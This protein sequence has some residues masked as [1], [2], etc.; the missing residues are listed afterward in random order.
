MALITER[1]RRIALVSTIIGSIALGGSK[2]KAQDGNTKEQRAEA[3]FSTARQML[4][5]RQYGAACPKLEQSQQLDPAVGTLLYLAFCY[6][7]TGR[8]S[9][10]W[11]TYRAAEIAAEAVGQKERVKIAR[12]RAT[13]LEP[14]L[15]QVSVAPECNSSDIEFEIDEVR[16]AAKE[17]T[18]GVR[19][20][21]G[22]HLLRVQGKSARVREVE[23][24][25]RLGA[26]TVIPLDCA[27]VSNVANGGSGPSVAT[28]PG[29]AETPE[30]S[31]TRAEAGSDRGVVVRRWMGIATGTVGVAALG[32]ATFYA[33]DSA[34]K[35][36]EAEKYRRPRSDVYDEPGFTLNREALESRTIAI[37]G[38]AVSGLALGGATVLLW[39]RDPATGRNAEQHQRQGIR[40]ALSPQS[41]VLAGR[42][43]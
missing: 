11:R 33:L 8:I 31:D 20:E 29:T 3:L 5:L 25:T 9:L 19:V 40:I 35:S 23:F 27:R 12:L 36:D 15:T 42:W 24:D 14:K 1:S 22:H 17:L 26:E 37:V 4:E 6:E 34:R 2:A 32:I 39:P 16:Y 10:A 28:L 30:G 43:N 38:F 41:F 18:R 7:M 21:A 13:L